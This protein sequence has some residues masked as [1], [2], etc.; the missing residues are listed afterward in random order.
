MSAWAAGHALDHAPGTYWEYLSASTNILA[1]VVRAQFASDQEYRDYAY[2]TL[3]QPLGLTTATLSPD[4][5]GTWVGSSYLWAST[6]DWA[7]LGQLM[8]YDGAWEGRQVIPTGW[9]KLAATP[10]M[11][12][13]EGHGYGAQ[14]W[15]PGEPNGGECST[16]A[17]YPRDTLLMEGHYG[18]IVAMIPS[19]D[20][21]IVRLGW[22][23]DADFDGCAF[24]AGVAKTLPN[25]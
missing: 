22:S 7:K 15:I 25:A 5:S 16:T 9:Q 6:A 18:Q 1:A 14:T 10:A 24:V 2:A 23:V 20:A 17:G 12:S 3:F 19:K 4:T 13:G 11:P 21:V 8:L